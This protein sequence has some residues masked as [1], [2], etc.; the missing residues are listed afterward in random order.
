MQWSKGAVPRGDGTT[1]AVPT[2]LQV[3]GTYL[4]Y[5][6]VSY[7]Y[8]PSVGYVMAKRTGSR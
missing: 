4:I 8:I 5:S 1:V 3:A 7:K 2:A 6:E